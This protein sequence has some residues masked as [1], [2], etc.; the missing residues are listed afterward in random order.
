MFLAIN[1]RFWLR[2]VAA[3][4]G[5]TDPDAWLR[6]LADREVI[7]GPREGRFP[8]EAEY[9]FQHA[10]VREAAY[11]MLTE[12]DRSL[13]HQLA[14]TW[15]EDRGEGDAMVLAEHFERGGEP[16]R[17]VAAYARAA[18]QAFEGHDL[19]AALAR[20]R[21]GID[22]FSRTLEGST[23]DDAAT[24]DLSLL[25]ELFALEAQVRR[26]RGENVEA[27]RAGDAA[28]RRLSPGCAAWCDAAGEVVVAGA[29]LGHTDRILDVAARLGALPEGCSITGARVTAMTRAAVYLRLA[30]ETARAE[31]MLDHAVALAQL[32]P[33]DPVASAQVESSRASRALAAG[34]LGDYLRRL[35]ASREQLEEAGDSRGACTRGLNVGYAH[36]QLGDAA[37]AERVLRDVLAEAERLGLQNVR[38]YA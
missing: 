32:V 17:A 21:R 38:T 26:W 3:L 9:G 36:L 24:R 28:M 1:T 11:G 37:Q 30:G 29:K 8:G 27:E 14:A 16:E 31:A 22:C 12:S 18:A 2:G 13:G 19:E 5:S 34:D 10:L 7:S 20:A 35:E 6:A 25:G 4:L 15:L 23:N 33:G